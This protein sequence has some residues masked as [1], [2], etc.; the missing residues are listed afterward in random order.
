MVRRKNLPT[1]SSSG[2]GRHQ[3]QPRSLINFPGRAKGADLKGRLR[4]PPNSSYLFIFM[5]R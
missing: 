1:L 3:I 5:I 2:S 4:E